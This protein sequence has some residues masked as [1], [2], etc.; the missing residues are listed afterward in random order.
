MHL[1]VGWITEESL[2]YHQNMLAEKIV[3]NDTD[4]GLEDL[5][6]RNPKQLVGG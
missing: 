3:E 2:F 1:T 5:H 6:F 4:I